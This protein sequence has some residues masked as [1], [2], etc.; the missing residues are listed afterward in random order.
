MDNLRQGAS[1]TV[2]A[3]V[4]T[5][6]PPK[7]C[8]ID[9]AD[10]PDGR[11]S[12]VLAARS[13]LYITLL[14][15]VALATCVF[16]LRKYGIFACQANLYGS[17]RYLSYCNATSYGDYDHGAIWFGLEP[18]AVNAASNARVLF[19]GNSRT[20]FAFSSK[21]TSEWF[22]SASASYYL[23]GFS[24]EENYTFEAPLLRKL[25]PRAKVYVVNIDSL[26]ERSETAPGKTVMRDESARTHYEEKRQWQRIQKAVCTT[27]KGACGSDETIF[28][29][30]STGTWVVTGNRFPSEP[31][32]Y[33]ENIDNDKL[34][35][36][37][38]LGK[39][40]LPGLTADRIC[41]ILTVVPTVKTDIQT[42]KAI[43]AALG[44]NLVAPQLAGLVTFDRVHLNPESAQR[45][46]A[47]FFAEAGPQIHKCLSE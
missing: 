20:Q 47:A 42:G 19:V 27:V 30:R 13:G 21:A 36:Y 18:A 7:L 39:Q 37:T 44:F 24:H 35:S 29:S 22:S 5:D 14:L 17:D 25:H 16:S 32:S 4:Q 2:R 23:L 8:Q 43:A 28:R 6:V 9:P 38:V 26:F 33:N 31:V 1:T 15:A 40:F 41:T 11:G 45:W 12:W 34:A 10:V 3:E 46:S